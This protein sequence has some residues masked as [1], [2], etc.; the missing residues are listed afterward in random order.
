M[1]DLA[2][3]NRGDLIQLL[4]DE[5]NAALE[6]I[7]VADAALQGCTRVDCAHRQCIAKR[8]VRAWLEDHGEAQ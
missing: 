3:L 6:V 7:K 1:S 2:D 5:M 4:G 8:E